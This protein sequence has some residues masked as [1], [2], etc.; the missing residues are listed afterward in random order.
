MQGRL[1]G[2]QASRLHKNIRPQTASPHKITIKKGG[3][4]GGGGRD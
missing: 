3:E 2:S 4:E 1:E